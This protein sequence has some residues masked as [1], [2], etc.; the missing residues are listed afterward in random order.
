[1]PGR[2]APDVEHVTSGLLGAVRRH[3]HEGVRID[4]RDQLVRGNSLVGN[5]VERT[6]RQVGDLAKWLVGGDQQGGFRPGFC[7][8][9]RR[10]DY[11]GRGSHRQG[12]QH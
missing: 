1:M 9:G 7:P 2:G 4:R 10:R 12:R 11:D 3:L 5:A 6:G 8:G